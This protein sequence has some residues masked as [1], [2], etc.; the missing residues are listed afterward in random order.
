M[1]INVPTMTRQPH[2]LSIELVLDQH[3]PLL[4]TFYQRLV[5]D[6]EELNVLPVEVGLHLQAVSLKCSLVSNT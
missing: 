1:I 5:V 4:Q 3:V 2:V 6:Y